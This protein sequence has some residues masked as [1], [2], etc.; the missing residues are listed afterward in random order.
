M[1]QFCSDGSTV[2]SH[3]SKSLLAFFID[4]N[5]KTLSWA[6]LLEFTEE[7]L[8]IRP[9]FFTIY[10]KVMSFY[11]EGVVETRKIK[12]ATIFVFVQLALFYVLHDLGFFFHY[13]DLARVSLHPMS[14][15]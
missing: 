10:L 12:I 3:K 14:K 2:F 6:G 7:P 8:I 4:E 1:C 11:C 5:C 15:R 9:L 13:L